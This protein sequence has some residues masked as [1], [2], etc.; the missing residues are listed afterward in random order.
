MIAPL[1]V[2]LPSDVF[3]PRCGGAGWSA[4]TLALALIERGHHVTA[5]VPRR[6]TN[7]ARYGRPHRV[8][9]VLGVPTIRLDYL[10]PCIPIV[11]NYFRYERFWPRF[12]DALVTIAECRSPIADC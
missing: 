3:P 7:D 5:I 4:H 10:A 12:A 1:R 9:D 8:E 6:T 11:Q 2:L